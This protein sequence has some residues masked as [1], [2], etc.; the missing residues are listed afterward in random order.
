MA[1][2][3]FIPFYIIKFLSK[4]VMYFTPNADPFERSSH[5][6]R[7]ERLEVVCRGRVGTGILTS[8]STTNGTVNLLVRGLRSESCR[9]C[10]RTQTWAFRQLVF[11]VVFPGI[12]CIWGLWRRLLCAVHLV[13]TTTQKGGEILVLDVHTTRRC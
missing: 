5:S 6:M 11:M 12:F 10:L 4:D 3:G 9:K 2:R 1:C 8:T 13:G 7:E